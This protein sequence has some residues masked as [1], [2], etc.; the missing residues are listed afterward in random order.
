MDKRQGLIVAILGGVLAVLLIAVIVIAATRKPDLI[1]SDFEAPPFDEGAILGIPEEAATRG[2]YNSI[3]VEGSY[4]FS[5]CGA[6]SFSEGSLVPYFASNGDNE[7]WLLLKV[8]DEDG[9]ELGKSGLIRPG[10]CIRSVALSRAPVGKT[11]RV[12]ILS[13]E[14]GTYYS[15]GTA[16]AVL[17]LMR[18]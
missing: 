9:T 18:E 10:E 5:I 4:R 17:P 1:V 11:V 13:Y 3:D 15:R 7:V 12:K 16:S 2:D 14:Q 8:Y 6:P